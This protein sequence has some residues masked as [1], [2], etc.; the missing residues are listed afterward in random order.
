MRNNL[1]FGNI[2]EKEGESNSETEIKVRSFIVENLKVAQSL[3][4]EMRFERVHRMGK[5][6]AGKHRLIIAK[7]TLYKDRE[8]VRKQSKNLKKTNYFMFEQYPKAIAEKRKEL[9]PIMKEEIWKGN[10]AWISYDTLYVN[11]R[12][13]KAHSKTT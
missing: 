2:E 10:N 5:M 1:I 7:F 3:V 8:M 13:M 11:G 12:P 4:D 9:V 6:V